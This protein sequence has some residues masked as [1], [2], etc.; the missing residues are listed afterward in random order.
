MIDNIILGFSQLGWFDYI[1]VLAGVVA[2][3]IFGCIPGLSGSTALI[4]AIPITLT[5]EPVSAFAVFMGILWAAVPAA[6]SPQ[7]LWEFPELLPPLQL[8]L[9]DIQWQKMDNLPRR[10][11]RLFSS[12]S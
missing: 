8:C 4:L 7:S 11:E 12:H 1:L 5:L 9:T 6:A 2:G 10:W 3:L